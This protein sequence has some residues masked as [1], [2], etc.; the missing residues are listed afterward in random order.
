MK[1]FIFGAG[2]HGRQIFRKLNHKKKFEGFFDNSKKYK[3][4]K[5]LFNKYIYFADKIKKLF[6]DKIYIFGIY[7]NQ[8][9]EQLINK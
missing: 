2:Y 3:S 6:F 8:I 5:K 9:K 7:S 1:N 4:K